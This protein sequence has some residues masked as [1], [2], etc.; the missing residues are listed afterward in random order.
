M[1]KL[2]TSAKDTDELF[3]GFD[4]DRGRRHRELT[5]NK[6]QK[7]KF[8]L[9]FFLKDVLGFA[10]HQEKRAFGFW[11]RLTLTR[12]TDNAV[13]KKDNAINNDKI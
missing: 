5:N 2:L 6:I 10:G 13:S 9:R 7:D 12:N 8:H 4:R 1:Y 11:Y 3:F